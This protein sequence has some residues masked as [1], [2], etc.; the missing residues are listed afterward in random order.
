MRPFVNEIHEGIG[1]GEQGVEVSMP[2]KRV[3]VSEKLARAIDNRPSSL[4]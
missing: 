1:R 3:A 4:K 2:M